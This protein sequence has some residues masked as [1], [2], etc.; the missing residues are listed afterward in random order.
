MRRC[1][2]TIARH[3]L[4]GTASEPDRAAVMFTAYPS[5]WPVIR[6][7]MAAGIHGGLPERADWLIASDP[8]RCLIG[9]AT[10]ALGA[11][12]PVTPESR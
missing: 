7:S 11:S 3:P 1:W 2:T 5:D 4:A 12:G 6:D 10:L 9:G 8:R